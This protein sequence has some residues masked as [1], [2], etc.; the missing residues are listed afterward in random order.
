MGAKD[1]IL[2]EF[3]KR[4]EGLAGFPPAT[5]QGLRE[6]WAQGKLASKAEIRDAIARG[7]KNVGESKVG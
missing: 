6:L 2:S 5:A 1:E 7:E 3:F 4:L